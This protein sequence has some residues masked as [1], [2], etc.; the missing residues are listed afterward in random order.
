MTVTNPIFPT[1][2]TKLVPTFTCHMITTYCEFNNGFAFSALSI[3]KI[4][5]KVLDLIIIT[6]SIMLRKHAFFT[7]YFITFLAFR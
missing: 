7:K 4:I 5:L 2:V 6:D 1:Y 3:M